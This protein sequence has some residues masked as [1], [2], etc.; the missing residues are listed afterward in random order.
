MIQS[1]P[2]GTLRLRQKASLSESLNSFHSGTSSQP[3][4]KKP[5]FASLS[6]SLTGSQRLRLCESR[7][8]AIFDQTTPFSTIRLMMARASECPEAPAPAHLFNQIM[9]YFGTDDDQIITLLQQQ[10]LNSPVN[11][12]K[13]VPTGPDTQ[14]NIGELSRA[15][16]GASTPNKELPPTPVLPTQL[17]NAEIMVYINTMLGNL[18]GSLLGIRRG[19]VGDRED[20]L[21]YVS[22][23]GPCSDTGS[24]PG[25]K[26]S[27]G[28]SNNGKVP[29][30]RGSLRGIRRVEDDDY[31]MGG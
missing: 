26:P 28:G 8:E 5:S 15:G 29:S 19:S 1:T 31:D 10:K 2:S 6:G 17:S 12:N 4:S 3:L 21:G 27:G 9:D 16:S 20:D 7:A 13:I 18:D 22:D 30:A 14:L 11:Q 25:D 23:Y 24:A